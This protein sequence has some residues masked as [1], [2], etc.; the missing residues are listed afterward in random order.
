GL[1]GR[2]GG[3]MVSEAPQTEKLER[4]PD[5]NE[6]VDQLVGL[7][8]QSKGQRGGGGKLGD[9]MR[10]RAINNPYRKQMP[11][12]S[13]NG[14]NPRLTQYGQDGD[15]YRH[16][17]FVAAT[18]FIPLGGAEREL[19][20]RY[21]EFQKNALNRRESI[22][23]LADDKAGMKVGGLMRNALNGK[24]NSGALRDALDSALCTGGRL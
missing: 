7:V 6:F 16:I 2:T 19:F 18:Y 24:M 14:F 17:L 3:P 11:N 10:D 4:N 20:Y 21:D 22:T 15:V 23:E 9:F 12:G 8:D 1:F 5:C 13:S